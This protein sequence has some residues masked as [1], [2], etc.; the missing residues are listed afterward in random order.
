MSD[1]I[2]REAVLVQIRVQQSRYVLGSREW[3]AIAN[4]LDAIA[5]LP[6]EQDEDAE[7]PTITVSGPVGC[8]KSAVMEI[9]YRALRD[10]GLHPFSDQL[11]HERRMVDEQP[12]PR[13]TAWELVESTRSALLRFHPTHEAAEAF[14]RYWRENGETHKH[15][16][17][18]STWGAINAALSAARRDHGK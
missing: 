18:E 15:G 11:A 2:S 4:A 14:W 6:V 7:R 9:I 5:A 13:E 16:Y 10:A 1:F 17:Y 8:G 3:L 12:R